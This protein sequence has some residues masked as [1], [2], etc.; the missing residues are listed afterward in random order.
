MN[1]DFNWVKVDNVNKFIY[2][3]YFIFSSGL[4]FFEKYA[5][6]FVVELVN[7]EKYTDYKIIIDQSSEPITN[8][9]I[10][11]LKNNY[12]NNYKLIAPCLKN[13]EVY[14]ISDNSSKE[15]KEW[16]KEEF[17]WK[18]ITYH[19]HFNNIVTATFT[20]LP[21][22]LKSDSYKKKIII[23]NGN[24]DNDH[25]RLAKKMMTDL[26]LWDISYWSFGDDS[27][28]GMEIYQYSKDLFMIFQKL[29]PLFENSFL[30]VVTETSSDNT[31]TD[32][33]IRVDFMSKMRSE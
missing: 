9:G 15:F 8:A 14:F 31:Y 6:E 24:M 12:L 7:S 11:S 16:I 28:F 1:L 20:E 10:Q 30:Y 21:K 26:N 4:A 3:N 27:N 23:I 33:N 13:K 32:T 22:K 19:F 5:F 25:K 17:G 2:F 29:L 18:H